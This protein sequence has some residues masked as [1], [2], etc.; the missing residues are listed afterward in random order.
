MKDTNVK[1]VAHYRAKL[2]ELVEARKEANNP[3]KTKQSIVEQLIETAH[4]KECK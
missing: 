1:L 2:D 3:F 4:K